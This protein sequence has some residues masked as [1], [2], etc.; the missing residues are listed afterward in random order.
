MDKFPKSGRFYVSYC[1]TF[2]AATGTGNTTNNPRF[3]DVDAGNFRITAPSSCVDKGIATNAPNHDLEGTKR[4]LDGDSNGVTNYD[5][6]AYEFQVL[7]P[8]Q[9]SDTDGLTDAQE[10][11][12]Y[13]TNPTNSDTD[14]D[15]MADGAEVYAGTDPRSP[16]SLL[17]CVSVTPVPSPAA[18]VITWTSISGRR[19][20]VWG[21]TNLTAALGPLRTNVLAIP[22]ANSYTD[23]VSGVG[24]RFYKIQVE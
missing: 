4:P 15:R 17:T 2:P 13:G 5:I 16:L 18:M 7:P 11:Y 12:V 9:D 23:S 20:T 14:G 1:C 19:Y 21:G 22:P 10:L 24:T 6:G 8:A 3:A